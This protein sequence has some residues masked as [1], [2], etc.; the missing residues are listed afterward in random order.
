MLILHLWHAP[1]P[2]SLP[3]GISVSPQSPHH[4]SGSWPCTTGALQL[5][6]GEPYH[7]P[8]AKPRWVAYRYEMGMPDGGVGEAKSA[9]APAD[10]T[11]LGRYLGIHGWKAYALPFA[12]IAIVALGH[13]IYLGVNAVQEENMEEE[14]LQAAATDT[15]TTSRAPRRKVRPTATPRH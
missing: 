3:F 10:V 8:E 14:R 4:S 6:A 15:I 13:G 9:V 12:L 1:G 5:E 2:D 11:L 7:I